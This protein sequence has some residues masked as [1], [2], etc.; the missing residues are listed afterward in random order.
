MDV[1]GTS[2]QNELMTT[3]EWQHDMY[4]RDR[5]QVSDKLTLDLGLRYEYYPLDDR[6]DRGIEK[7]VGADDLDSTRDLAEPESLTPMRV[8]R[9]ADGAARRHGQHPKD[10]GIKV[11]KT[12]FAP[13][14]GAVYRINENTVFRA[15]YGI[16]YNPLPFSRPLR[17]FYPLT[18][19]AAVLRRRARTGGRPRSSRAFRTSSAPDASSGRLPLP[20]PDYLMRTP[21]ADVSR[22]RIQSWNV[23]FERRLPTT[24]R[25]T[26]PTSGPRRTAASPTSTPTPR[27]CP[28]AATRAGRLRHA[29]AATTRC[30]SGARSRSRATT[31]CRSRSTGR[32]RTG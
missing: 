25:S 4:A 1:A 2:V 20:N 8:A 15:G 13:R 12:L 18:L 22:S 32:S 14:L 9:F 24:S 7:I 21:A 29:S 26:W 27:T 6:A 16:T 19:A 17:G 30:C 31:R 3:R 10:L 28:A 23:S 11:S 5:W